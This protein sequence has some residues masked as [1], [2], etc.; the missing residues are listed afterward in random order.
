M[1]LHMVRSTIVRGTAASAS[2]VLL[3]GLSGC[4]PTDSAPPLATPA[5]ELS[6]SSVALGGALVMRYRFTVAPDITGIPGDY[7]VFVHFLDTDGALMF[8]DDHA[9]PQPTGGWRPGQEIEYDRRMIVPLYPYIGE[10]TVA[11]GLYSL[12]DGDRLPLEG[13]HLGERAYQVGTV[14]MV[15]QS[16]NAFGT[17]SEN[18]LATYADGWHAVESG[19]NRDWRWTTGRATIAFP[20]PRTAATLH[21]E[22]AGHSELL[23]TAQR[24]TLEIDGTEIETLDLAPEAPIFHRIDVPAESLGDDVTI[25]L[26]LNVEGTFV[27]AE[28]TGNENPDQRELGARVFYAFL[29][30]EGGFATYQD[31]WYGVESRPTRDW[32]W[33][34]GRAT[35]A[36]PN[37]RTAATL[38]LEVAGRPRL[39]ETAQ[40]LTL[41]IGETELETLELASAAPIYHR[42]DLPAER[43]GDDVTVGLTLNVDVTFVPAEVTGNENPDER[44]LGAQVFYAFLEGHEDQ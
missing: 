9:P 43:L 16:G 35:I 44:E 40:R 22:V 6:R 7:Q 24:L 32:R 34:A 19:A 37:P 20:N 17:D 14:E 5:V 10:A 25:G 8:T 36:F 31:G 28:L 30:S 15:P 12:Q 4:G 41:E 11:V 1:R 2:L 38:H 42:I 39:F 21:L 23:E 3:A 29:E 26:T 18:G 13:R 33:T 27:P